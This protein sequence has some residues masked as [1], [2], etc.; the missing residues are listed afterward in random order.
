MKKSSPSGR[1]WGSLTA[2]EVAS[3]EE[4]QRG[5]EQFWHGFL[6][7]HIK[8]QP[9]VISSNDVGVQMNTNLPDKPMSD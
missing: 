9:C 6:K 2:T 8:F 7:S 1:S 5:L 3:K 4:V